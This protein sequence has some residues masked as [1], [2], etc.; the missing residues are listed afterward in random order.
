MTVE[1]YKT[2]I[3]IDRFVLQL[4]KRYYKS[5][6]DWIQNALAAFPM[7]SEII[8]QDSEGKPLHHENGKENEPVY[9]IMFHPGEGSVKKG[10][11]AVVAGFVRL[12]QAMLD[13]YKA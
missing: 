4:S 10:D 1:S 12:I 2:G 5:P 8:D 9:R 3:P 7:K 6:T 11:E 13:A